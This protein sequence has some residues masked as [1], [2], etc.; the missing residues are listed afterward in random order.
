MIILPW[1]QVIYI[2]SCPVL[3]TPPT[4]P[5]KK[6]GIISYVLIIGFWTEVFKFVKYECDLVF[7]QCFHSCD[8]DWAYLWFMYIP[9]IIIQWENLIYSI[10]SL[11]FVCMYT[12]IYSI[13]TNNKTLP[14]LL[15]YKIPGKPTHLNLYVYITKI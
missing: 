13:T 6:R 11:H 3:T 4:P 9:A 2:F 1:P 14:I 12:V 10:T 15:I 5:P 8:Y 7:K